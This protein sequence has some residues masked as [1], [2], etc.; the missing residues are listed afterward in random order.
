M[1]GKITS[2]PPCKDCEDR[3][4]LCWSECDKYKTWKAEH[5]EA[6]A[7]IYKSKYNELNLHNF[8]IEGRNKALKKRGKHK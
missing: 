4:K 6:K 3:H 2:Y 5:D 8:A 7:D 1:G